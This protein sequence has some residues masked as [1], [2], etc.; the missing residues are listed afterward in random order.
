VPDSEALIAWCRAN[1][2]NYR[3]PRVIE[4]RQSLPKTASGKV[5]KFRLR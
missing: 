4:F 1:M 5:E 2:A 3:V